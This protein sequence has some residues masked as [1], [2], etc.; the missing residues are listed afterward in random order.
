MNNLVAKSCRQVLAIEFFV[1]VKRGNSVLKR[2]SMKLFYQP[3]LRHCLTSKQ[4]YKVL[5]LGVFGRDFLHQENGL[6]SRLLPSGLPSID[7][8]AAM[9]AP[10]S[11]P[12]GVFVGSESHGFALSAD[13]GGCHSTALR[14]ADSEFSP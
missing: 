12:L 4:S 9:F 11:E 10:Q 8:Q 5:L 7:Q 14:H 1:V 2:G 6:R 13:L 3:C